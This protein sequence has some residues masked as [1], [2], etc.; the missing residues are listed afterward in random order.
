MLEDVELV[1][2]GEGR[3]HRSKRCFAFS[4]SLQLVLGVVAI[5]SSLQLGL[6]LGHQPPPLEDA[7]R[8][9]AGGVARDHGHVITRFRPGFARKAESEPPL[10]GNTL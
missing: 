7:W 8:A 5:S 10:R 1:G 4:L 6:P 9:C 2:L 3:G